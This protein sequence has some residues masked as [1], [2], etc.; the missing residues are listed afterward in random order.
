[1]PIKLN[2]H[3]KYLNPKI[4]ECAHDFTFSGAVH[5]VRFIVSKE[6][7]GTAAATAANYGKIFIATR[8]CIV[9]A[10]KEVHTTAGNDEDDVT[11]NVERL[12]GTET[13]GN[14][15]AL[16]SS[17]FNLKGTKETVQTGTLT[18]TTSYLTLATG[19]RLNLVDSGTLTSVAGVCVAVE[20]E[21]L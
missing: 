16:L 5:G 13:S 18:S 20:L 4:T 3:T 17:A 1:M 19:D 11:L 15:D 10:I 14:G 8:P 7:E 12:Q 9:R 2:T 6:L 21:I